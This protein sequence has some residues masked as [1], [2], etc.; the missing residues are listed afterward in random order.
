MTIPFVFHYIS[1]GLLQYTLNEQAVRILIRFLLVS[2][3][4]LDLHF[5]SKKDF[6]GFERKDLQPKILHQLYVHKQKC[7]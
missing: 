4:I 2:E 6:I 1:K 5:I 7:N 3:V